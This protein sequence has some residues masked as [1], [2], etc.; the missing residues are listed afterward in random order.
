MF[1]NIIII[2][3]IIIICLFLFLYIK[4]VIINMFLIIIIVI[5]SIA[6]CQNASQ[7]YKCFKNNYFKTLITVSNN[8]MQLFYLFI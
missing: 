1:T 7:R 5:I 8:K 3:I 6:L 2:I 4:I